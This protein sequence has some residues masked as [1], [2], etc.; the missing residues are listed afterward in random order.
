[1]TVTPDLIVVNH[2]TNDGDAETSGFRG[3]LKTALGKIEKAYP[4]VPI[5]YMLPFCGNRA[6]DI[7]TVCAEFDN[8]TVVETDKWNISYSDG[9]HPNRN[10]AKRAGELL[11]REIN[12]LLGADFFKV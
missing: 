6:S 11:S 7:R 10:G 4:G 1:M 8:I 12:A 3:S 5:V 9:L 2:G